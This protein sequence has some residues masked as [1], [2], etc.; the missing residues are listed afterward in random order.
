[1]NKRL[2]QSIILALVFTFLCSGLVWA[3]EERRDGYYT[4]VSESKKVLLKTALKIGAGDTFIDENND[5]YEVTKIK[6]DQALAKL[7]KKGQKVSQIIWFKDALAAEIINFGTA[8]ATQGTASRPIAIYHTHSDESY[9]P[10]DGTFSKTDRGG[11][12]KVGTALAG[13]YE[14][15]GAK[16]VQ[17]MNIHN[18]HD[19]MAYERSRRTVVELLRKRP[20]TLFDVHR[21]AAPPDA[22]RKVVKGQTISQ[23]LFVIG[24]QNPNYQANLAYAKQLKEAAN[25]KYPGLSKGILV[26]G[27]RFNQ[28]LA[29]RKVLLEFGAHTN[30]RKSAERAAVMFADATK[31]TIVGRVTT[32]AGRVVENQPAPVSPQQK[33]QQN[34]AAGTSLIWWIIGL[35]AAGGAFLL[36]NEGSLDGI[37]ARFR[38][39]RNAEFTNFLGLEKKK[40]RQDDDQSQK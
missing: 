18:P 32:S 11:I 28:D 16:V 3:E 17:N 36:M 26:T 1:V 15:L 6:G 13:K 19:G 33:E 8:F 34:R 9:I 20:V 7:I 39:L 4:L 22:Y 2:W 24:N 37:K 25:G 10:S 29:P 30:S 14:E 38:H 27:G 5:E 35:I 40:N 31:S 23:V 12:Y 21:D